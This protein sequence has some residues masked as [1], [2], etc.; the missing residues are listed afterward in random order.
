MEDET[1]T[2]RA[3]LGDEK[4]GVKVGRGWQGDSHWVDGGIDRCRVRGKKLRRPRE[5]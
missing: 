3:R 2:K 4:N 1:G 5:I